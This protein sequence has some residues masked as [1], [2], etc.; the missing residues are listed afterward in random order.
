MRVPFS[1]ELE[2]LKKITPT[3]IDFPECRGMSFKEF[4]E[5]LPIKLDYKDYEEELEK[6]LRETKHLWVKKC[7]GLGVT[8]FMLRWIAW[9]CLKDDEWKNTQVDVNVVFVTGPRIDLAITIINR[10]KALFPDLPR[11]KETICI[12][13]GNK[14]EAYPSHHVA[15]AHG[16]NPKLIF[17]DEGDFFP[18]NQQKEA[19]EVA[20]RY[21]AK[22]N[23]FIVW[24]STPYLP[25]GLFESIE[26]E[27]ECMYR[28]KIMLLDRAL[29][30]KRYTQEQVDVWKQSPSF[31]RE[32]WGEY[33]YG[34]GD[35]FVD[36]DDIIQEY[37]LKYLGGRA[38]TY[39]DPGFGSSKFGKIAGEVRDGIIYVIE[40]EEYERESPSLMLDVME[41][42]WKRHKQSCKVDAANPG[43]IKDLN[44]RGIPALGIAFG[45]QVPET[46][47]L[48]PITQGSYK[49]ET[50]MTLKKK[51]PI[52]ASMMVKRKLVRIHPDFKSLISQMRAVKFDKKGGI[53]KE[54]VP[55]DLVD[56]FDMMLWDMQ[57]HDYSSTTIRQDGRIEGSKKVKKEGGLKIQ[58]VEF[59]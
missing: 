48:R 31:M 43:F 30:S 51:L 40:S 18:P 29:S 27:K 25:G 11:T 20:E 2:Q 44:N 38:G 37:D 42:S 22:T 19:R 56:A 28:R 3:K 49:G 33:G 50:T 6:D 47:G 24:V 39:A 35:I 13:N 46:E 21:I 9:N 36:F 1:Y 52:N 14:I 53:D 23:P 57:S 17:L 26:N 5:W 12:L 8:E 15:T 4:W 16:L 45:E 34:L 41:E 55:F 54:E 10:L 7:A 32:A 58:T 59:S